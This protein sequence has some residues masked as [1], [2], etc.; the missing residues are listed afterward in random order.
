MA[1]KPFKKT[2]LVNSAMSPLTKPPAGLAFLCGVCEAVKIDYVPYDINAEF[3][4]YA[5]KNTW[6][7]V[8]ANVNIGDRVSSLPQHLQQII[9][10][11]IDHAVDSILHHSPDCVC[12][13]I[14]T[15]MQQQ[16]AELF[17]RKFK[18][19]SQIPVIA[20][21]PGVGVPYHIADDQTD[22]FGTAMIKQKL[23][24][25][26]VLGEGDF[27]LQKF[28]NGERDNIGLNGHDCMDYF[29]PQIDDLNLCP[30]LNFKKINLDDYDIKINGHKRINITSSRGCVRKCTFCDVG[31][32]W[33]KFRYRSGSKVVDEMVSHYQTVGATSFA[34]SDSL[35][36]GSIKQFTEMLESVIDRAAEFD[37]KRLL[38][39]GTF[40]IRPRQS[41]P[42][43]LFQ[44]MSQAGFDEPQIGIESGSEAVRY[45][46]GKNFSNSDIDWH[47]EMSEK[48]SIKNWLFMLVGYPT[49]T[50]K[51]FQDTCDLLVKNQKY[52]LNRTILGIGIWST[53]AL[54]PGTPLDNMKDELGLYPVHQSDREQYMN[55]Q[56]T[57]NPSL[58][59]SERNK[60]FLDL[61][62]LAVD[63]RYPLPI[64]VQHY[65]DRYSTEKPVIKQKQIIPIRIGPR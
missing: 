18:D 28:L 5:D 58:T 2:V 40:I 65:M 60:R 48:Y 56:S 34:F 23:L 32:L 45:H 17:L 14:T 9:N 10:N 37:H 12:I 63:L 26:Y 4:K 49:E 11:F 39:T 35:V 64:Q 61:L 3:L 13:T 31:V 16:W 50:A 46:I 52:I 22:L 24:D 25:Y 15:I 62:E 57:K 20:G 6:N 29:Q 33:K 59:L 1:V 55:W 53:L 7:L 27:V 47:F 8:Y 43:K 54:L 30:S 38:L 21:G 41:H 19:R 42:E 36:N 51:D 44:L